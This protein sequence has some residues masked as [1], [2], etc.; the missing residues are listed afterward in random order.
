MPLTALCGKGLKAGGGKRNRNDN[1]FT[2]IVDLTRLADTKK[3]V[4]G[5]RAGCDVVI[6]VKTSLALESGCD[7]VISPGAQYFAP[8]LCRGNAL[9]LPCLAQVAC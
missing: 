1:H 6:F 5:F 9:L 2:P 7:L 3:E 4:P 8:N